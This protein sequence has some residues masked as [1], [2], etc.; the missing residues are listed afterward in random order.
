VP[1]FDDYPLIL[2]K[3][4]RKMACG[5]NGLTRVSLPYKTSMENPAKVLKR[6]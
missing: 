2:E 6:D 3:S 5:V 4:I 1:V